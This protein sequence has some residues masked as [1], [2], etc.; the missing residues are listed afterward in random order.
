MHSSTL[1]PRQ[2]SNKQALNYCCGCTRFDRDLAPNFYDTLTR[3]EAQSPIATGGSFG[4][5]CSPR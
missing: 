3:I 1:L 5:G 2:L 4:M